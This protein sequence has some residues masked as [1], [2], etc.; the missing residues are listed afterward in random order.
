MADK[1]REDG[2]AAVRLL[3]Y[4]GQKAPGAARKFK[5]DADAKRAIIGLLEEYDYVRRLENAK[6]KAWYHVNLLEP[7]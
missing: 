2:Q 5:N 3:P 7:Q 4:I 1:L 6:M